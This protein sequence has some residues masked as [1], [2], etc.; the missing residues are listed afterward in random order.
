MKKFRNKIIDNFILSFTEIWNFDKRLIYILSI[1]VILDALRPFPSIIFS[2]KIVDSFTTGNDF[3]DVLQYII[4]M[5]GA[6][7]FLTI[8]GTWLGKAQ[9][10][11]LIKLS[12]KMDNE[13]NRKCLNID[14]E[15]F[16]DSAIQDRIAMINQEVRGNNCFKSVTIVFSTFSHLISLIGIVCVMTTLNG[17][18][19][20]VAAIVIALQALVHY[21]RLKRDRKHTEDF[22]REG[23]K[24]HYASS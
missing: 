5:F 12:N 18:L 13:V 23:R 1:G 24:I 15:M 11:L 22:A 10:Y 17:S 7:S 21:I 8:T 19:L 6:E 16:N 3:F 2:G 20:I 4:L 9:E 14:Y